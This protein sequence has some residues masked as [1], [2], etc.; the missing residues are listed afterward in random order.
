MSDPRGAG[1]AYGDLIGLSC[2][3]VEIVDL[4]ERRCLERF[5]EVGLG[6]WREMSQVGCDRRFL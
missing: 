6:E 1:S 4:R 3:P 5:G 2:L